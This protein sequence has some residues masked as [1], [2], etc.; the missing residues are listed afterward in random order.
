MTQGQKCPPSKPAPCA[1]GPQQTHKE[2]EEGG[3]SGEHFEASLANTPS[4]R[5]LVLHWAAREVA[6][7]CIFP[8]TRHKRPLPNR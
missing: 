1:E 2:Q 4:L 5:V 7:L 8:G 3:L 6:A